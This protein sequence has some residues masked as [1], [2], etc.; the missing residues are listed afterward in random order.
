M[1]KLF[2]LALLTPLLHVIDK[3]LSQ[4]MYI[5][6]WLSSSHSTQTSGVLERKLTD[7]VTK[8]LMAAHMSLDL[9]QV[10]NPEVA[11]LYQEVYLNILQI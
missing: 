10:E 6:N 2:L 8:Q 4:A 5:P 3:L 9:R 7:L 1:E 11:R